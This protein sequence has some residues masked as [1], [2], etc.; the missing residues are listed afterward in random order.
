MM[1]FMYSDPGIAQ[2]SYG[3]QKNI[4]GPRWFKHFRGQ[5]AI[6][7]TQKIHIK[8]RLPQVQRKLILIYH[9]LPDPED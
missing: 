5:I 1:I 6:L 8:K 4:K 9:T 2:S 7:Y 3:A